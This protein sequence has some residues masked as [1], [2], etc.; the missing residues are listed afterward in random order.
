MA[1]PRIKKKGWNNNEPSM[2]KIHSSYTF[3][4]SWQK[5]IT[6]V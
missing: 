6:N 1:Q 3:T 2:N 4:T 5:F